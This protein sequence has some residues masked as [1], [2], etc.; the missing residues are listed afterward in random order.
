MTLKLNLI[1]ITDVNRKFDDIY[2]VYEEVFGELDEFTATLYYELMALNLA[3]FEVNENVTY[4][5]EWSDVGLLSDYTKKLF[6]IPT[7]YLIYPIGKEHPI[8]I[9]KEV[10]Y[11]YEFNVIDMQPNEERLK[12]YEAFLLGVQTGI[13]RTLEKIKGM[14]VTEFARW[15]M[16][17]Q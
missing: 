7:Y 2:R 1:V 11:K 5:G 14:N 6:P 12:Q 3:G 16:R 9:F 10:G 15:L 17:I 13:H 4:L 8:I